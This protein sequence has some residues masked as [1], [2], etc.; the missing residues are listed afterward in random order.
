MGNVHACSKPLRSKI[1]ERNA[2]TKPL[3]PRTALGAGN[4]ASHPPLNELLTLSHGHDERL[5]TFF[6]F[7]RFNCYLSIH[8][9]IFHNT[10]IVLRK[11]PEINSS[12]IYSQ[13][14]QLSS[15]KNPWVVQWG[16]NDKALICSTE[17]SWIPHEWVRWKKYST[18][19]ETVNLL[20]IV[21][22]ESRVIAQIVRGESRIITLMKLKKSD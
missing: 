7:D 8:N 14:T 2:L 12:Y 11:L 21:W 4:D 5:S 10:Y 15:T 9:L 17:N 1:Q 16:F 6:H 22:V 19:G 13:P 20:I 3:I 18:K